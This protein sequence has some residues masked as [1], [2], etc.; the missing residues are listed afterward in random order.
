[1]ITLAI[2]G[3][4]IFGLIGGALMCDAMMVDGCLETVVG[5]AFGALMFVG[6]YVGIASMMAI[7]I[8]RNM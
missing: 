7:I 8:M 5:F 1:M 2:I 3:L 6:V 4:V